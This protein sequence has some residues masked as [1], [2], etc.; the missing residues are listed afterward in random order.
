MALGGCQGKTSDD[1]IGYLRSGELSRWIERSPQKYL[2]IDTRG[3]EA[4]AAGHIPGARQ[5]SLPDVDQDRPD[6]SLSNYSAIIVYG[7]DPSS[8]VARAMSKRLIQARISNVYLLEGGMV[9]WR[10]A[11]G[12][13]SKSPSRRN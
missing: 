3:P 11:G 4:F 13:V 6:P 2:I 7:E 8:G 10:N 1:S 12:A 9:G 5:M